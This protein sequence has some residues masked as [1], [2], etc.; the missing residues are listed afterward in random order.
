MNLA[1]HLT[2]TNS[3]LLFELKNDGTVLYSRLRKNNQLLNADAEIV[4]HNFFEDFAGFENV[5][6]LRR[7][8]NNFVKSNKFT[9]NFTF[10]C[11][12][13]EEIVRVRVMLV[14]AFEKSYPKSADIVILDIRNGIY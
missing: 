9:D 10:E 1:S 6:D 7:L 13:P 2:T 12:F 11:R 14:R 3:S 8:F 4:G 5:R